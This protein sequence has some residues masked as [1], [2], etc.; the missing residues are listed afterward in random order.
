MRSRCQTAIIA[1]VLMSAS[2]ALGQD[3]LRDGKLTSVLKIVRLQEGFAGATGV[4]WTI[5]PDGAWVSESIGDRQRGERSRGQLSAQEIVALAE[6]LTKADIA[7]LPA[8]AGRP[9]GANPRILRIEF[10]DRVMTLSGHGPPQHDGEDL[11]TVEG[12]FRAIARGAVRI[13]KDTR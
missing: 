1:T 4:Q 11:T 2:T 13:L 7:T 5:A 6:L 10:D 9:A 12:R 3:V 8:T